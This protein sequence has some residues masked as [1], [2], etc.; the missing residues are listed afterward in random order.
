[1]YD[2]T[3]KPSLLALPAAVVTTTG[4]EP[5]GAAAG[6]LAEIRVAE[7]TVNVAAAPLKVTDVTPTKFKPLMMTDWFGG[8][9]AGLKPVICGCGSGVAVRVD[10][11]VASSWLP[12]WLSTWPFVLAA[13]YVLA[14]SGASAS[15]STLPVVGTAS[16][17]ATYALRH[18]SDVRFFTNRPSAP[19]S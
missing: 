1:M 3:L 12:V 7:S 6:T 4:P 14:S 19:C 8:P 9:P 5:V 13:G 16:V 15:L 10:V 11:L 2:I 18:A 17:M